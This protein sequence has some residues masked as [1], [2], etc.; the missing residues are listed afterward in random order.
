M[1]KVAQLVLVMVD[2]SSSLDILGVS[3]PLL[4]KSNGGRNRNLG[5]KESSIGDGMA[6]VEV[7]EVRWDTLTYYIRAAQVTVGRWELLVSLSS[8]SEGEERGCLEYYYCIVSLLTWLCWLLTRSS[9]IMMLVVMRVRAPTSSPVFILLGPLL[10]STDF[11]T[12]HTSL[13]CLQVQWRED[14]LSQ[15]VSH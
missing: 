6:V 9:L 12:A 10:V 14:Q 5:I 4:P 8:G 1:R 3:T 7:R 15:T 2:L 13:P 11:Y